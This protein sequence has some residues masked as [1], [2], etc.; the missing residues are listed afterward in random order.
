[1]CVCETLCPRWQQRLK[2]L[3]LA[4]RSKLRSQVAQRSK[5]RSQ[6]HWPWCHFK[7]HHYLSMHDK[8][9]PSISNGSKV[10]A[11]CSKLTTDKQTNKQTGQK[12]YTPDHSIR[13]H[14]NSKVMAK[15][16]FCLCWCQH[17]WYDNS[18]PNNKSATSKFLISL[19]VLLKYF[20]LLI[21]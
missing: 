8:Y 9:E 2:R 14:K 4:Q 7:G 11:K 17:Q 21:L 1:M 10:T 19:T 6:G 16:N 15:V 5:S 12:Q 13:G 18:S 20:F 3:L